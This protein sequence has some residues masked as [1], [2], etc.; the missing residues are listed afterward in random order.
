MCGC[1]GRFGCPR[2]RPARVPGATLAPWTTEIN[3][4][5]KLAQLDTAYQPRVI[6]YMNDYKLSS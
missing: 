5:E 4:A 3:L 1:A 6:G 2:G